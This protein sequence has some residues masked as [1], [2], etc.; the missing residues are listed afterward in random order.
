MG[1]MN[2]NTQES[3]MNTK[4]PLRAYRIKLEDIDDQID[5]TDDPARKAELEAEYV[6]VNTEMMAEYDR[7]IAALNG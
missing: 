7:Q 4:H 3:N 5:A 1:G 2:A 6:R